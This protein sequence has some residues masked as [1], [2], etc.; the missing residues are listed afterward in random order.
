MCI[1]DRVNEIVASASPTAAETAVGAF[2]TVEGVTAEEAM[3][4][5]ELPIPFIAVT[6]K[7]YG[8]PFVSPVILQ[9]STE[10]KDVHVPEA[11]LPAVYAVTE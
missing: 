11:T 6:L 8:T 4:C 3:D 7:V 1:R 9:V 2:G 10:A 5:C